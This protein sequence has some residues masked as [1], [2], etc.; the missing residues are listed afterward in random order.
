MNNRNYARGWRREN[1]DLEDE[2]P[3]VEEK[4][5]NRPSEKGKWWEDWLEDLHPLDLEMDFGH[6]LYSPRSQETE[7]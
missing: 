1:E 6:C 3:M 5:R 4:Q 2:L 7:S